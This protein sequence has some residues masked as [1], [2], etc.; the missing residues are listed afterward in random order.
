MFIW[1]DSVK[2]GVPLVDVQHKVFFDTFNELEAHLAQ[3][4]NVA[5]VKKTLTFLKYY[6]EWH[7]DREEKC[8]DKYR[9]P[10]ATINKNAHAIFLEKFTRMY[11][12]FQESPDAED[13]ARRILAELSDWLVNHIK[14]VD[15]HLAASIPEADKQ[16][17]E[18][19]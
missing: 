12:E 1:D 6:A 7:F 10:V 9:C 13:M 14:R 19:K 4:I 5:T 16:R 17:A 18:T 15:T 3:G 11:H 8:M 2:T